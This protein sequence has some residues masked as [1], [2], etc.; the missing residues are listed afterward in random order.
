MLLDRVSHAQQHTDAIDLFTALKQSVLKRSLQAEGHLPR[1]L[2]VTATAFECSCACCQGCHCR[3]SRTL[4]KRVSASSVRRRPRRCSNKTSMSR[5]R[6]KKPKNSF[7]FIYGGS[8]PIYHGAYVCAFPAIRANKLVTA[9]L[10]IPP[11]SRKTST[12]VYVDTG[13][14]IRPSNTTQDSDP[15]ARRASRMGNATNFT[16]N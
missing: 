16:G 14:K 11:T 1:G 7:E 12:H 4:C 15:H 6:R 5:T 10:I 9:S 13:R 2:V 8:M 3:C